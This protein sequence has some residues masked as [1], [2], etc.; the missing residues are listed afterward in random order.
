MCVYIYIH[1]Y[2]DMPSDRHIERWIDRLMLMPVVSFRLS[3]LSGPKK[4]R[5]PPP[6]PGDRRPD[7]QDDRRRRTPSPEAGGARGFKVVLQGFG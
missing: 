6:G 5:N 7:R 1:T 2:R 4:F 3:F